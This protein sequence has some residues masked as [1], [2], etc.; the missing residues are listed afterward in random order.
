M[1]TRLKEFF[2]PPPAAQVCAVCIPPGARLRIHGIP[3]RLQQAFCIGTTEDVTFTQLSA[4]VHTYRDAVR[5]QNGRELR[6]QEL[7]EG[8]EV[9]VVDLSMAEQV[10]LDVLRFEREYIPH[11]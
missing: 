6:L 4:A 5:F 10:D 2:N 11:R 1:M 9:T 7:R 3:Q 8:M